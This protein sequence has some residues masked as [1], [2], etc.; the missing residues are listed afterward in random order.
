M[1]LSRPDI[2]EVRNELQLIEDLLPAEARLLE[3]G[4]GKAEKTRLL[5]DSPR[6]S[7]ILALEVDEIQHG[8]NLQ[9]TDLPK[10]RFAIGGAENI[11]AEDGSADMVL[12]FKSLHHVPVEKMDQAL[13]EIRRVLKRGGLAWLS[14]PIFAGGYNEI[15]RLF[16]D[17]RVVREAAFGAVRRAV[18]EG[19]MQFVEQIFFNAVVRYRDFAQ[20]DRGVLQVTHT[21]H[22]LSP[23]LYEEVRAKFERHMRPD[24]AEFFI[25]M[26][27]DL[28]RK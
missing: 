5:A 14:E 6:V 10:V 12:M 21:R 3:L 20:F 9:I 4:C 16:H 18:D 25:P 11:P 27:V 28:L 1:Q 7:S 2:A 24:G 17:E 23:E 19:R 26:R 13:N 8:R 22:K 15:L